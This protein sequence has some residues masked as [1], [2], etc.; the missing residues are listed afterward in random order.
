MFE[1]IKLTVHKGSAALVATLVAAALTSVISLAT[2]KLSAANMSAASAT[3]I[4]TQAE[5]YAKAR[6]GLI[7]ATKYDE[8][9]AT[10]K[11]SLS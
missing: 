2:V 11:S 6:A 5:Q 3:K 1:N 7:R 8:L 10:S 9:K 4:A